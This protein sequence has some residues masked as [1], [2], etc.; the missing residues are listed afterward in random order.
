M[1]KMPSAAGDVVA[2]RN[3]TSAVARCAHCGEPLVL[4]QDP[5]NDQ[6]R[7]AHRG[8]CEAWQRGGVAYVARAAGVDPER[9]VELMVDHRRLLFAR[10]DA[11]VML[12]ALDVY[13]D[14]LQGEIAT[15][16]RDHSPAEMPTHERTAST[17]RN[18]IA[19]LEAAAS[20][21]DHRS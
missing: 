15:G 21:A 9:A 8:P 4:A 13:R 10:R 11:E 20:G 14:H 2:D 17:V 1:I 5:D 7:L 3:Q 6:T 19:M 12:A 16:K 18:L